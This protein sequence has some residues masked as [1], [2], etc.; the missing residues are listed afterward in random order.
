MIKEEQQE[1]VR[2]KR[3]LFTGEVVRLSSEKT[4]CV[5]VV[6]YEMHPKYR[7]KYKKTKRYLVHDELGKCKVGNLI[8]F[9]SCRPHSKRKSFEFLSII[10][11]R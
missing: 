11:N 1:E 5:E 9:S 6:R 4:L 8:R 2:S 3:T 10:E 7:K